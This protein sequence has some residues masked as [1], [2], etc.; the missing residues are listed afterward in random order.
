MGAYASG[1][2]A[3]GS[4]APMMALRF[5]FVWLCLSSSQQCLARCRSPVP[6]FMSSHSD[7]CNHCCLSFQELHPFFPD[8]RDTHSHNHSTPLLAFLLREQ[9]ALGFVFSSLLLMR[10]TETRLRVR[11]SFADICDTVVCFL[12]RPGLA[13][14][15]LS[16]EVDCWSQFIFEE[17]PRAQT[18]TR[19]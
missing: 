12:T 14:W 13:T 8:P 4:F 10:G 1:P 19:S 2:L 18:Q 16:S 9:R 6:G 17:S 5:L 15:G 11:D 3:L 7:F